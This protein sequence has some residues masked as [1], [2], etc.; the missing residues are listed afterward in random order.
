MD[1]NIL[2]RTLGAKARQT[3]ITTQRID[4]FADYLKKI[5]L[6]AAAGIPA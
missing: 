4:I 5:W 6:E 1:D 3:I 2:R